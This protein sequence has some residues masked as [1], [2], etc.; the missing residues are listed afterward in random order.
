MENTRRKCKK[1]PTENNTSVRRAL[2]A[3][4][5]INVCY[6]G[7]L[8]FFFVWFCAN[9]R[10]FLLSHIMN[11]Y[12]TH[13]KCGHAELRDKMKNRR[14]ISSDRPNGFFLWLSRP[15]GRERA[16]VALLAMDIC[17]RSA[18]A[19][20]TNGQAACIANV[21]RLAVDDIMGEFLSCCV[22][23][24]RQWRNWHTFPPK[25]TQTVNPRNVWNKDDCTYIYRWSGLDALALCRRT[26]NLARD[27]ANP[28]DLAMAHRYR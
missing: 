17:Q 25:K 16:L 18:R 26:P 28:T 19:R 6:C 7:C 1:L 3:R 15:T 11:V 4:V 27:R 5:S 12:Y 14:M 24:R 21:L 20:T 9:P 13:I 23:W 2:R 22:G 8:L 10:V